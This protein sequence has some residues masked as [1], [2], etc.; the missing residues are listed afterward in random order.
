MIAFRQKWPNRT[1]T[2][3]YSDYKKY[4]PFLSTDFNMRCG[5][6]DV[7]HNW[8]G[9]TMHF[10]IDHFK[11]HSIAHYKHLKSDYDNLVYSCPLAN[12]AKWND[13]SPNYLDPCKE[14]FNQHFYRDNNGNIWYKEESVQGKYMHD[15]LKL[16]L[17]CYGVM[18]TLDQIKEK[19]DA[20]TEIRE[21]V[22]SPE[23]PE[24][25]AMIADLY[26]EFRSHYAMLS[27]FYDGNK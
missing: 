1:C 16:Y 23:K 25:D 19:L 14:N 11:P 15:K 24:I 13:D 18:W 22:A 12:R 6:T 7:H 27:N 9:G 4:K 8:F 20:I 21:N 5:Y 26:S 17:R 10:Q 2:K 3:I